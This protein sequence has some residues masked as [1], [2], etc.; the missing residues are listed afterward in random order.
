ESDQISKIENQITHDLGF[1]V[2]TQRL[3]ITASCEELKKMG[4]CH[5]KKRC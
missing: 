4:A 5:K 2:M 1:S 3:Q